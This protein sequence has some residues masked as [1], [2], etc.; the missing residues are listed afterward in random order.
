MQRVRYIHWK[1]GEAEQRAKP[2]EALGYAVEY[3][4]P[5]GPTFLRQLSDDSPD[6]IVIDLSRVPSQGRDMALTIRQRKSTRHIPLI[7]LEGDSEKVAR[8]KELLPDAVYTSWEQIGGALK[9]A[10]AHPPDRP[11][12]PQSAMAGYSGAPLLKKLGIKMDSVVALVDAPKDFDRTLGELPDGAVLRQGVSDECALIIWFA[13][14]L[15][16]LQGRMEIMAVEADRAPLWIAWP[17]KA[18]KMKTD[19][20]QQIVREAGLAAGLVDYKICSID[21]TWSGLLFTMR[22]A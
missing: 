3:D 9:Q 11:V 4:L 1:A 10:I 22:K 14:S 18:S 7:F 12:V 5:S 13:R 6:A 2:I 15:A 19:L 21:G 17:K 16:E 20:S 8:V